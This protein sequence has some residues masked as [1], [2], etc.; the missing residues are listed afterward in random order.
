MMVVGSKET[1]GFFNP[2][3]VLTMKNNPISLVKTSFNLEKM[4]APRYLSRNM[5][6]S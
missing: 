3:V 6:I 1:E 2:F 5:V 4:E